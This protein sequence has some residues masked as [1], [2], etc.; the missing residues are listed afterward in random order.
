MVETESTHDVAEATARDG[1]AR[2]PTP[3]P[4]PRASDGTEP[5]AVAEEGAPKQVQPDGR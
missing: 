2:H 3:Q 4:A 1:Q 5:S